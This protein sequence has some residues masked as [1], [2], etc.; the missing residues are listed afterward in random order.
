MMLMSHGD[1]E[2]IVIGSLDVRLLANANT[3]CVIATV[4]TLAGGR[5]VAL[6][7]FRPVWRTCCS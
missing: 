3:I 6:L 1:D 2:A 4:C 5:G 7:G